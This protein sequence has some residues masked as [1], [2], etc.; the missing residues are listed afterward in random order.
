MAQLQENTLL[1]LAAALACRLYASFEQPWHCCWGPE[2]GSLR[3]RLY[4][5]VQLA[6]LQARGSDCAS[7]VEGTERSV[8]PQCDRAS[9]I[10]KVFEVFACARLP[11]AI[12]TA[13]AAPIRRLC[14][15]PSPDRNCSGPQARI[16]HRGN[17][18]FLL[19]TGMEGAGPALQRV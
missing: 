15:P 7:V 5:Y 17:R 10:G 14:P 19:K 1:K 12:P 6:K 9:R 18:M 16:A 3:P 13:S 11:L 4:R 8:R 2:P